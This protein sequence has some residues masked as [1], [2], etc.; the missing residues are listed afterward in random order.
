VENF[1][2]PEAGASRS[3]VAFLPQIAPDPEQAA[4]CPISFN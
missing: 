1:A 4:L 3:S 2:A